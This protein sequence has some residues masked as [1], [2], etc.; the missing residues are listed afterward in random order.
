MFP[1]PTVQTAANCW[2]NYDYVLIRILINRVCQTTLT[3]CKV[4]DLRKYNELMNEFSVN[5][6]YLFYIKKAYNC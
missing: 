3:I 5:E 2:S 1:V 4:N 6:K